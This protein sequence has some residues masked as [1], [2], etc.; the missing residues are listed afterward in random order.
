VVMMQVLEAAAKSPGGAMEGIK[1][2]F[3]GGKG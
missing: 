2:L 1:N 3:G